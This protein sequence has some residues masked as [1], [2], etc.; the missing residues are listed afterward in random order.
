MFLSLPVVL[1]IYVI[2]GLF[3]IFYKR[4]WRFGLSRFRAIFWVVANFPTLLDK[5]RKVQKIRM[6][7]DG[8]ALKPFMARGRLLEGFKG[9]IGSKKW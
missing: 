4:L 2:T 6:L 7:S 5:R 8:Q 9:F 3:E 1:V